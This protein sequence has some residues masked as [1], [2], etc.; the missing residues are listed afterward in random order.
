MSK[1]QWQAAQP[2]VSRS[3]PPLHVARGFM[4]IGARRDLV[5][6]PQ[7]NDTS[8]PAF[9]SGH[10]TDWDLIPGLERVN[11]YVFRGDKR[12][13]R[14]IKA[15]GGFQPPTMRTDGAYADVIAKRFVSY[16][17]SRFNQD[18]AESAVQQYIQGQ[19][20][21]GRAFTEYQIW[22]AIL[23]NE[24]LH[25]GRMVKDEFLRGYISTTR[26]TKT[27]YQFIS[28][29]SA[30][31]KREPMYAVYALHSEGG[32]LL[33]PLANHIHGTKNGENEIAHPGPL[34]WSK[35]VAFRTYLQIDFNNPQ[36]FQKSQVIFVR[37]ELLQKD[38]KGAEQL[39]WSLGTLTP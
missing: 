27:A 3:A 39:I 16:M 26:S 29:D 22:R 28:G 25:I 38:S 30:D 20:Q 34:P 10:A 23:K 17:K 1:H 36:S 12:S 6:K 32:F 33:P 13:P 5:A 4:A 21:A 19:G 8:R 24:E 14:T 15:A 2:F 18:I 11:A 35:V 31:G 37:K 9:P 7:L